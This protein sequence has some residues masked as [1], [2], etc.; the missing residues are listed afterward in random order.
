MR[1]LRRFLSRWQN[2]LSLLL[3]LTYVG[4]ALA[5]PYLSPHDPESPG[6][7]MQVGRITD[8]KPQ[9]P[10]DKAILG[11]LPFGVDVYHALIWGS[12]DA[13]Q[14]GLIVT[15]STALFGV[16]YGAVSGFAG[17]RLGNFMIRLSD[18]FLAFPP[19]AGL[20]FLQQLFA[21]TITAM[22]GIYYSSEYYGPVVEITGPMTAI[23]YLLERVNPLMLSLIV[24][25]WMPYAR[26]VHAIVLTLKQTDFVQAARALGGSPFW[27]IRKHIL[28]NSIGP[29]IVLAARDVGGVVLLQ[30]T[31]T[32]VQIGGDSVWGT[33]LSQG[34]NW[35][36][37]A[38]GS[39]LRYWWV[40]LP[41]TVAVMAF[42][43]AWNM[44]GDGLNDA[45]EP[46]SQRGFGRRPFWSA[47]RRNIQT[48]SAAGGEPAP[49]VAPAASEVLSLTL[50]VEPVQHP[51][52][53]AK[54]GLPN[55]AD[56]IL[57]A[58]REDLTRGD[59]P[60]A[61]HAYAHLIRRGRLL[62]EV[63][64]D[65]ARLVKSHPRDAQAWQIL[66]DALARAGRLEH[67]N[68]SYEQARKLKL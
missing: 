22:G 23:Q 18:S 55:G 40:Y 17:N 49:A 56:P 45:L 64:P 43:I 26:L 60:R 50:A 53:L 32:F 36:I 46:T 21:T 8:G 24:F 15:L 7:F 9:P 62:D 29:A 20:V 44:L 14:F 25:S 6:P 33:M 42:G 2:W 65:L 10:S 67:A 11:M 19:I 5:A 38:G 47:W 3:I 35:V 63:L 52:P 1:V 16:L 31:L 12:R 28:R 4:A 30:A 61:L 57:V 48:P 66:G 59:V 37:G 41:P 39:L 13:L 34:R 58:A 54:P 27:I 68:Q 51:E